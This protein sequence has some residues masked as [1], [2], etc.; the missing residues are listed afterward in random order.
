MDGLDIKTRKG[1]AGRAGVLR[2]LAGHAAGAVSGGRRSPGR[3]RGS[4]LVLILGSLA[5]LS[6]VTLVYVTIGQGDRRTSAVV[7]SRD[8]LRETVDRV[9]AYIAR[10]VIGP[11]ALAVYADGVDPQRANPANPGQ[12]GPILVRES[13]DYPSTDPTMLS[14]T[15]NSNAVAIA[16]RFSAPGMF[17]SLPTGGFP[18]ANPAGVP[19][20]PTGPGQ[21]E[22]RTPCDP[23]LASTEPAWLGAGVP[24][25]TNNNPATEYLEF[26]DWAHIS[27]IAPSG[28]FVNL[29]NLAPVVGGV[30]RPNFDAPA[31]FGPDGAPQV[32]DMSYGM[33][34]LRRTGTGNNAQLQDTLGLEYDTARNADPHRPMHWDSRQAFAYRPARETVYRPDDPRYAPYQWADTDGDGMYDQRWQELVDISDP[35]NPVSVLPRDDR[36]RWFIA[37]RII[38]LSGLINVNTATEFRAAPSASGLVGLTPGDVDLRRVLRLDDVARQYTLS[39]SAW[40]DMADPPPQPGMTPEAFSTVAYRTLYTAA[41]APLAGNAGFDGL[42]YAVRDAVAPWLTLGTGGWPNPVIAPLSADQR[43]AYFR[44]TGAHVS[45]AGLV[46]TGGGQ[47]HMDAG[48]LFGLPDLLEL[49][50]YGGRNDPATLSR[51]EQSLGGRLDPTTGGTAGTTQISPLR[52]NLS[53]RWERAE[54]DNQENTGAGNGLPDDDALA[55]KATN[56]RDWL[57][58][59]GGVRP[60]RSGLVGAGFEGTLDPAGDLKTDAIGAL[61]AASATVATQRD[62]G[63]L[64]AAYADALLPHSWRVTG[65][66]ATGPSVW[67]TAS[68]TPY[69]TL[70]YG[71]DPLVALWNA[72]AMTANAIDMFDRDA[73]V[74][75]GPELDKHEPSAFTLALAGDQ[76]SLAAIDNDPTLFPYWTRRAATVGA[77]VLRPGALDL[78]VALQLRV[79]NND[80]G[81]NLPPSRMARAGDTV[82]PSPAMNVFGVEAQ[83]FI[84]Q[85]A[86]LVIYTDAPVKAY[87]NDPPDADEWR[88]PPPPIPGI[89]G[90]PIVPININGTIALSNPDI[91][92][93]VIAFQITNPFDVDLGMANAD[94]TGG[95]PGTG[96]TNYYVE[97][98]GNYFKLGDLQPSGT[99]NQVVLQRA[100][101]SGTSRTNTRVFYA[102]NDSFANIQGRFEAATLGQLGTGSFPSGGLRQIIE[103]Q[104]GVVFG[105]GAPAGS[106]PAPIS[107]ALIVRA[108]P[109]SGA[110][111]TGFVDL[112]ADPAAPGLP[113]ERRVVRLWRSITSNG[114]SPPAGNPERYDDLLADR[115]YDP[116][117]TSVATLDRRLPLGQNDITGTQA[118]PDPTAGY[119]NAAPPQDNTGYSICFS[120]TFKR[121]DDP[122][123]VTGA[124]GVPRGAIPAYCIETPR[125]SASWG[126]PLNIGNPLAPANTLVPSA[127]NFGLLPQPNAVGMRFLYNAGAVGTA[128]HDRLTDATVA[129]QIPTLTQA[130]EEKTLDVIGSN[131]ATVPVPYA[132]LYPQ[133]QLND[134]RF[135]AT[136]TQP[137]PPAPPLPLTPVV[138]MRAGDM[139]LPLAVAPTRHPVGV[140]LDESWLTLSESLAVALNYADPPVSDAAFGFLNGMG[141]GT[142][143]PA[144]PKTDRGNL[145]LDDF[146]PYEDLNSDGV[147]NPANDVPRFPFVPLG[148]RVLDAFRV[149]DPELGSLTTSTAGVVNVNT[150]P[151]RVLSA[152]PMLQPNG[153]PADPS[154]QAQYWNTGTNLLS[155]NDDPAGALLAYRDKTQVTLIDTTS[156]PATYRDDDA[157][158]PSLDN[159][160]AWTGR[161][162]TLGATDQVGALTTQPQFR[163]VREA[164]GLASLGELMC[165][166]APDASPRLPNAARFDGMGKEPPATPSSGRVGVDTMLYRDQGATVTTAPTLIDAIPDDFDEKLI[167]ANA[168]SNTTSVRSDVFAVWFVLH[169]YQRSDVEGLRPFPNDPAA[170]GADPLVPTVAKRYLMVVDRSNV[171]RKGDKPRILMLQELPL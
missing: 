160:M 140:S 79:T 22:W 56:V 125:K 118:G 59:L 60:L 93:E 169:G 50:T 91:L 14:G 154:G 69:R 151:R 10:D 156:L 3:R 153:G 164:P 57:T 138:T 117:T 67:D 26:L 150:A 77:P 92:C 126:A 74:G 72:A 113:D 107:P 9:S 105:V 62:A 90:I 161:G 155:P 39:Y 45:G 134:A 106:E 94:V 49:A 47:S 108:N 30:R 129:V 19:V 16:R 85:A 119:G 51:L 58:T 114:T 165:V 132:E 148:L 54:A 101:P 157:L 124:G 4:V 112:L 38:D 53:D 37:T 32:G 78:D 87:A 46:V 36:Y 96:F 82:V 13:F 88:P 166:T 20:W 123:A 66:S 21:R 27:N 116:T 23:W 159:P 15:G 68:N 128:L 86:S 43:A 48:G 133:V 52:D 41:N 18:L 28:N 137:L 34:L 121:R 2:A 144:R 63:A 142:A 141:G 24:A 35:Q 42:R 111:E 7:T 163:G 127:L 29:W 71:G 40:L 120:A 135:R 1:N 75:A 97:F 70:F 139:L 143:T 171:T 31:G 130:P 152:L 6:V 61:D 158:R 136:P 12:A 83:P 162:Y 109:Q 33:N 115:M 25:A 110:T 103:R 80:P 98:N 104:L 5:M 8:N 149:L 122:G 81:A 84:V 65:A 89:P 55:H 64:F 73:A 167:L 11:D 44:A 95:A 100:D 76:A 99:L 131:L 102:L 146:V 168:V 147:F 17:D 170:A 145:V